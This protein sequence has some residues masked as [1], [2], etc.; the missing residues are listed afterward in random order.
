MQASRGTPD[1]TERRVLAY[2]AQLREQCFAEGASWVRS[3]PPAFQAIYN[4]GNSMVDANLAALY[5]G[6]LTFGQYNVQLEAV[7][8]EGARKFAEA[9][10]IERRETD[11]ARRQAALAALVAFPPTPAPVYRPPAST[12][13][14][15][16]TF[17][18]QTYCTTR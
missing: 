7:R 13:T 4:Y 18:N 2:Y 11:Q 8:A 5:R 6:D 12:T 14:S 15:C 1:E 16:Q 10:E 9:R 17:G 3:G